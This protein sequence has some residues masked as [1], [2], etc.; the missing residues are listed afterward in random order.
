ML[1]RT[2]RR[3]KKG[4]TRKATSAAVTLALLALIGALPGAAH[5]QIPQASATAL[6]MGFN[7]T[8]GA[9]G[10]AAIANNPAGLG[11]P[12]SP[13]FSLAIPAV[14]VELGLGPVKLGE[15]AD[16]E[17]QLVSDAV[18]SSWLQ[19]IVAEGGQ[20]GTLGA[21]VTPLAMTIGPV[22]LQV[23][24]LVGGRM[25]LAPDVAELLLYG[26]AG[27]TGSPGDFALSGSELDGFALTT[28]ALSFGTRVSPSFY[29]GVTGTYVIGNG[30]VLG[31]DDGSSLSSSPLGV[32]LEFPLLLPHED[33]SFENGTGLGLDVGALWEG[34]TLTLGATVQNV[35]STF[36]WDLTGHV[37]RAGRAIYDA[38]TDTTDFDE[39]PV[40]EAPASLLELAADRTIKPVLA[41]GAEWRPSSLVRV[42]GDIRKRVS[43]G[44]EI[45]PELHAGVGAELR[46][47]SFFPLRAHFAVVTGGVQVGGGASLVLGPVN[48]TGA[49]AL[50]TGDGGDAAL[51]MLT[52]SFGAN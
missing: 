17:G 20:T 6:G 16:V 40:S 24:V 28:T 25:S 43:G 14:A 51:G 34:P 46:A 48:L 44:L 35:L 1:G 38:T 47:L 50:R 41:V 19:R 5:A 30:L 9:R 4:R 33:T 11:H 31:R 37:F 23:G 39:R 18:K 32:E 27:R 29:V 15:L 21:G 2:K 52:L 49:G 26:N 45:G 36:E 3:T 12:G 7:M 22:G 10:F 13:G 42:Q 8:A